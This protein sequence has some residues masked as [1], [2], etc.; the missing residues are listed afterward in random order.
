MLN[1][2]STLGRKHPIFIILVIAFVVRVIAAIFSKGFGFDNEHFLYVEMP[3]SWIDN[4]EYQNISNYSYNEPQGVSL[5][6]VS[7]NY[8][9]FFILKFFGI[10][11]PQWL[12][13]FSRLL[14]AFISLFVISF[15]Y[16]IAEL[17]SNKRNALIVAWTLALLWFMSYI[18]VHNF[19]SFSSVPF[20]M[21]ASLIILRQDINRK[22]NN[23]GNVHRSSFVI[24][25]FFLGLGFSI[26]YQN[27]MYVIG[28]ILALMLL[29]NIRNAV[30]TMIGFIISVGI[31]Q[32]IPDLI[33]WGRPFAE[34]QVFIKN[35]GEYIFSGTPDSPWIYYS[36]LTLIICLIIPVSIMMLCGF[37]K[38]WRK[39]L[40]L[41]LPT[42][43]FL[44]YYTIFP[45]TNGIYILPIIPFFIILGI[46][47]WIEFKDDS[48]FWQKNPRIYRYLIGFSVFV[49]FIVLAMM[50]TTYPNKAEV[51]AL[52]HISK[53]KNLKSIVIEDKISS[54]TKKVPLFYTRH[55]AKCEII[56]DDNSMIDIS[57][58]VD[59][60]IFKESKDIEMRV[61][62]MKKVL[63]NLQYEATF[64][65]H[66]TNILYNWLVNS[67]HDDNM[68]VYKNCK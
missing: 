48:R 42:L 64:K 8:I 49:N 4:I 34:L 21:Y 45:N 30:M 29:K 44:L 24:A 26:W 57:Q 63:P 61:E 40:L 2:I 32:L 67:K 13:F 33:V 51:K 22:D 25:G 28:I 15:G 17:I 7:L 5:F 11:N 54:E 3:N 58:D 1:R 65:P 59:Y 39:H 16:R 20:L 14:H 38:K 68:I 66:Y 43:L 35:S 50:T 9:W 18:S 36:F 6:Y 60:V 62:E 53:D 10:S 23:S 47:G 19:A 31:V 12:M 56:D 27:L 41:F 46:V 52:T 37:F 55:W